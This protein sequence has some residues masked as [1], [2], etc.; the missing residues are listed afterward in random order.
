[1]TR[2]IPPWFK[3]EG[4]ECPFFKDKGK[5]VGVCP[6]FGGLAPALAL[7][8]AAFVYFLDEGTRQCSESTGSAMLY[9][10]VPFNVFGVVVFFYVLPL[11][12]LRIFHLSKWAY[13]FRSMFVGWSHRLHIYLYI[14]CGVFQTVYAVMG[15]TFAALMYLSSSSACTGTAAY[16]Y[17]CLLILSAVCFTPFIIYKFWSLFRRGQSWN[18]LQSV[19]R[20][21]FGVDGNIPIS[22]S[23]DTSHTGN[24]L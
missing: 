24:P 23:V 18:K 19:W 10:V 3:I 13:R 8:I 21:K 15:T 16:L 14:V 12:I 20:S 9:I 22:D 2:L 1:M 17:A 5:S 7:I 11:G 6:T 4:G